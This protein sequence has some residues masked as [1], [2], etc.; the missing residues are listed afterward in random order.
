MTRV[1]TDRAALELL[2]E[3]APRLREAGVLSVGLPGLQATLAPAIPK[4]P[5]LVVVDRRI[6]AP[7]PVDAL[8]DPET[9]GLPRGTRLPWGEPRPPTDGD[10]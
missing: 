2:L 7:E 1:D 8:D 6:D 3:M 5:D 4:M 9:Y 10:S